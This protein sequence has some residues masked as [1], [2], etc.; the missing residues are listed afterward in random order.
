[1][2]KEKIGYAV[3]DRTEGNLVEGGRYPITKLLETSKEFGRRFTIEDS[4]G[5]ELECLEIF[6]E[7]LEG[8]NWALHLNENAHR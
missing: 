2:S 6:C 7:H 4:D 3:P 5:E 1:M 8:G